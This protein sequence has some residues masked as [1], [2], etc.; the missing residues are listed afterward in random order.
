MDSDKKW[1]IMH[2]NHQMIC[3]FSAFWLKRRI[4]SFKRRI[5]TK[6]SDLLVQKCR[7]L[8]MWLSY[9]L[10]FFARYSDVLYLQTV[11]AFFFIR[12]NQ[13]VEILTWRF[14]KIYFEQ[15]R[16]LAIN[17]FQKTHWPYKLRDCAI[18]I[19]HHTWL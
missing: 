18:K 9:E 5:S 13:P 3:S 10:I 14:F 15:K 6:D 2:W 19:S 16:H 11:S 17:F 4:L 8:L 7:K 12:G 1:R